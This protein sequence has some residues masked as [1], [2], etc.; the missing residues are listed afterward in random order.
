MIVNGY[1]EY[2]KLESR[3]S[4]EDYV[5]TPILRDLHYHPIENSILC[6]GITF[7]SGDFYVVSVNHDDTQKFDIPKGTAKCFTPNA[8][9]LY[10]NNFTHDNL[11]DL[12]ALAY[13]RRDILPTI[14][15]FFT[16]YVNETQLMFTKKENLNDIIPLTVWAN[17]LKRYN[18]A[19]WDMWDKY[20]VYI[21]T[22]TYE[23]MLTMLTTLGNIERSGMKINRNLLE[24][25][26]GEKVLRTF[27][28][29]IIYS[30]Y[31]PYTATGRPSNRFGGINFAALNKTDGTREMFISRYPEG[32]L[33]QMDFEAYHLHLIAEELGVEL[34][35]WTSIHTEL[36]KMYFNTNLITE[37]MY[38]E[39]KQRT[40]EVMYGQTD[41]TYGF[42]LFEKIKAFRSKFTGSRIRL[43]N[44]K[45]IEVESPNPSKMFNY[46]VQS[47]EVVRTIPKLESVLK[48]IRGTP[49][50]LILYTYDSI[51]LDM[52][53]PNNEILNSIKFTLE[54][55]GKYP[56]RVS[57]GRT[58]KEIK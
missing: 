6:T 54:E 19:L 44:G 46:Y 9:T 18:I 37:E 10:L 36:A 29:D 49:N 15:K 45:L 33:V 7:K 23:F 26:F 32:R 2:K 22:E 41:E 31:N 20:Q 3:M 43:P 14:D 12:E 1:E 4:V 16:P 30:E 56:V 34:P 57:E 50:H 58:Y 53:E 40:F 11:F 35:K 24:T 55:D 39:S 38:A 42:E 8:K 17:I 48:V 21:E 27:K 13:V 47:L 5:L 28:N 51:L 25:N 52:K